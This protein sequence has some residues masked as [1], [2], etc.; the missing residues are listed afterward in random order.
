MSKGFHYPLLANC[1]DIEA[2]LIKRTSETDKG[3]VEAAQYII[4]ALEGK[5]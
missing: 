3:T 2:R 4:N 1:K 5:K